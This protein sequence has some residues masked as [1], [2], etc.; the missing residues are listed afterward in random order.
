MNLNVEN[1]TCFS[2]H[3]KVINENIK[4]KTIMFIKI[5]EYM[6]AFIQLEKEI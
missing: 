3:M 4:N 5:N 1:L 2:N 6:L